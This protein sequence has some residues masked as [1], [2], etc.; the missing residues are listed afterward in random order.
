MITVVLGCFDDLLGYGLHHFLEED[1]S[2]EVVAR[3]MLS[4]SLERIARE[5]SPDVIIVEE[6]TVPPALLPSLKAAAPT[7]GVIVLVHDLTRAKHAQFAAAGATCLSPETSSADLVSAVRLVASGARPEPN[8]TPREKEVLSYLSEHY[9]HAEIAERLHISKETA[10][11][12]TAS[13]RRK[14]GVRRN[15]E[16]IGTSVLVKRSE[17]P[18]VISPLWGVKITRNG[19]GP[20]HGQV[21]IF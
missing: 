20:G 9:T 11:S 16:L 19:G 18:I 13:I 15:R 17:S 3:D 5:S 2:I 4:P 7:A 6:R 14:L 10:R 12:H 1:Q 21:G 8:L